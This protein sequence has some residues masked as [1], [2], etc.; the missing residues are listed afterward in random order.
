M[1]ARIV[2]VQA[3]TSA[4]RNLCAT[5]PLTGIPVREA[6]LE[7]TVTSVHQKVQ[8]ISVDMHVQSVTPVAVCSSASAGRAP[9]AL[10]TDD[11]IVTAG[12]ADITASGFLPEGEAKLPELLGPSSPVDFP[13]GPKGKRVIQLGVQSTDHPPQPELYQLD[14]SVELSHQTSLGEEIDSVDGSFFLLVT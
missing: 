3:S 14:V 2:G 4:P 9:A 12:S 13:L 11:P 5:Q 6:L 7:L 8:V 10:Q 1:A